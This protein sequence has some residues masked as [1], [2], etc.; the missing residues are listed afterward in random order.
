MKLYEY[1]ED[2]NGNQTPISY[3]GNYYIYDNSGKTNIQPIV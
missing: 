3:N 1:T 2:T